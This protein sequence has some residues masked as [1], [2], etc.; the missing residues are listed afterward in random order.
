MALI[1]C[2]ECGKEISDTVSA[3][4]HCGYRIKSKE[5]SLKINSVK[6]KIMGKKVGFKWIGIIILICIVFFVSFRFFIKDVGYYDKNEW[7]STSEQIENKYGQNV[8]DS[9]EVNGDCG[10]QYDDFWGIKGAN[11]Q[12]NF[13]FNKDDLLNSVDIIIMSDELPLQNLSEAIKKKLQR[14]YG[15]PF[16]IDDDFKWETKESYITMVSRDYG[17]SEGVI[18]EYEAIKEPKKIIDKSS[19]E[20]IGETPERDYPE[21]VAGI[22]LGMSKKEVDGIISSKVDSDAIEYNIEYNTISIEGYGKL[23][24]NENVKTI[25]FQFDDNNYLKYTSFTFVTRRPKDITDAFGYK[26]AKWIYAKTK[27]DDD[28]I[29]LVYEEDNMDIEFSFYEDDFLDYG[30]ACFSTIE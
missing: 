29:F 6:E 17:R 3:C 22:S 12:V 8:L 21:L 2:P 5:T 1:N 15:T 27:E 28:G 20:G 10:L 23:S 7:G 26:D 19:W 25:L 4:I 13:W 14:M 11:A 9:S 18:L 30:Y 24:S 16:I